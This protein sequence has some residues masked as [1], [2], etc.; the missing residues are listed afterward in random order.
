MKKLFLIIVCMVIS[1]GGLSAQ[2]ENKPAKKQFLYLLRLEK[3]M[4]DSSAWTPEKSEIV[5][6]HFARLKKMLADGN[7][8]LAGRTQVEND[9]TFGIVI[10]EANSFDEAKQIAESDPAVKAK[11]MSV[12]VYPYEVALMRGEEKK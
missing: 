10:Y 4:L 2:Q 11:I 3:T 12:E 5:S 9:K 8:I 1:F 6:Q 7:L